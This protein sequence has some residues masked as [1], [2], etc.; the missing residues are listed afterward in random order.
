MG[1]M[2]MVFKT[3]VHHSHDS[4]ELIGV[5]TG[6]DEVLKVCVDRCRLEEYK[7]LKADIEQIRGMGQTQGYR[8]AGEFYTE[9]H[10]T[11]TLI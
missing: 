8:G 4:K 10:F 7:L 3:D 6:W 11:N 2:I 5:C 1:L 9:K